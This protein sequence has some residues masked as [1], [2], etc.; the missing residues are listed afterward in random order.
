MIETMVESMIESLLLIGDSTGMEAVVAA[1]SV[2][3]GSICTVVDLPSAQTLAPQADLVIVFQH[4]PDEYPLSDILSLLNA[5]P[6]TR[7]IVCQGPWCSSYGRTRQYWPA[8]VCVDESRWLTRV[9]KELKVLSGECL[10][11][12][13][14]AGLD[15]IFA[16][17]YGPDGK[18]S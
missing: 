10:P 8:A 14:T 13:W 12:P 15:E 16:F 11:L 1:V 4:S 3:A 18:L 7:L 5:I 17:D 9:E 2:H 6:L